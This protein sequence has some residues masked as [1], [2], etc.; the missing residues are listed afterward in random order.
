MIVPGRGISLDAQHWGAGR[1]G[2]FLR[3]R[4]LSRLFQEKLVAAHQADRLS[5]FGDDIHLADAQ[6][7]AFLAPPQKAEWIRLR[8]AAVRRPWGNAG[9]S[10]PLYHRVVIAN[11]RLMAFDQWG[12]T[13]KWKDYRADDPNCRMQGRQCR[14]FTEDYKRQAVE[15]VV[16]SGRSVTSV[17]IL[18]LAP[19]R[20]GRASMT[21]S[22]TRS[23]TSWKRAVCRG[24]IHLSSSRQSSLT[25]RGT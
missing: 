25:L 22:P 20:T 1:F 10:V 6:S 13:F 19:A 2:F 21:K 4:V 14:L 7:L 5:F 16:S 23:S 17:A 15:L 11:G 3:V 12:V 8:Q 9:L 18:A 24:F